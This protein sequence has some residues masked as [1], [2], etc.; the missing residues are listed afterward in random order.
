MP[1]EI[2]AKVKVAD[3]EPIRAR[4]SACGATCRGQVLEVNRILDNAERTLLSGDRGL[5][6]RERRDAQGTLTG[7]VLT[8]KGPKE[9]GPLKRREEIEV[10][11]DDPAAA[12]ALLAAL[13]FRESVGFEK[14][15][16][17]WTY[18]DCLIELDEVP[19]LG[20]FVEIEGPDEEAIRRALETLN[21]GREPLIHASYIALLVQHCERNG[22]PVER[23][24][25]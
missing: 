2:E 19:Y 6:I 16:E 1:T 13:G 21:M 17:T 9:P 3:H 10:E 4:L 15:R 12:G 24:R 7:A 8:Y 5:R 23:I 11:I 14:R 22:L 20:C 25:F 18:G